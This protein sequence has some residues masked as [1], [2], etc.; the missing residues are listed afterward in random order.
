MQRHE[1]TKVLVG[2]VTE[3]YFLWY[4]SCRGVEEEIMISKKLL[5]CYG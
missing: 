5:G 3:L 1:N 2:L 4:T